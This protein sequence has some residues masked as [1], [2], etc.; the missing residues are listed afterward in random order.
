MYIH[1]AKRHGRRLGRLVV[2]GVLMESWVSL[3]RSGT[4]PA[5]YRPGNPRQGKSRKIG[6]NY[7]ISVEKL[8]K[9][10]KITPKMQ[11]FVVFFGNFLVI[12]PYFRG[13]GEG[14]KFCNFSQF[15]GI[16][17]KLRTASLLRLPSPGCTTKPK[18][19]NGHHWP[20][21]EKV[22]QQGPC[23]MTTMIMV[24]GSTSLKRRQED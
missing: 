17:V 14:G 22:Q 2:R 13:W 12:F 11:F 3:V 19:L 7:K 6:E 5:L 23:T 15:F 9:K 20:K 1:I 10:Y 18:L 4:A 16:F 21:D 24:R 8:P